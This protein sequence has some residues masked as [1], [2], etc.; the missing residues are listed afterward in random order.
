MRGIVNSCAVAMR[1]CI[2]LLWAGSSHVVLSSSELLKMS[3]HWPLES[4]HTKL[5]INEVEQMMAIW[6][7]RPSSYCNKQEK[8]YEWETFCKAFIENADEKSSAEKKD[9]GKF[10][11][12]YINVRVV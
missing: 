12:Y 5:F 4:F 8:A 2:V 11:L 1:G 9:V 3:K 6:Y 7:L 10:W